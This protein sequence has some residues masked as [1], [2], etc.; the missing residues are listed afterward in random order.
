MTLPPVW[1]NV[2]AMQI[3]ILFRLFQT[4]NEWSRSEGLQWHPRLIRTDPKSHLEVFEKNHCFSPVTPSGVFRSL[5]N[6]QKSILRRILRRHRSPGVFWRVLEPIP[7]QNHWFWKEMKVRAYKGNTTGLYRENAYPPRR[8]N[9]QP[10]LENN[11][12]TQ[13]SGLKL[14]FSILMPNRTQKIRGI[15][16]G[17][18]EI[19][20]YHGPWAKI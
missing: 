2:D 19:K 5:W 14:F 16:R 11:V 18:T 12:K 9:R 20:A 17:V 3:L 1:A 10:V 7:S 4:F 15:H 6:H 8:R 13:N